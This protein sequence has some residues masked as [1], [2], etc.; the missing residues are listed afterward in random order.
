MLGAPVGGM[1]LFSHSGF[2]TARQSYQWKLT[3]YVLAYHLRI[4]K[5]HGCT[6]KSLLQ[7]TSSEKK[8][9]VINVLMLA[10]RPLVRVRANHV[11]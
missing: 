3:V 7:E 1:A 6:P 8:R 9:R 5:H 4:L 11:M 2:C 10:A